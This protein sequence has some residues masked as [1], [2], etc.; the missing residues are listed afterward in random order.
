M[1]LDLLFYL[2][3]LA[4]ILVSRRWKTGE[5]S[6][7]FIFLGLPLFILVAMRGD[8]GTDTASYIEQFAI[9]L[10]GGELLYGSFEPG[11]EFLATVLLA[12]LNDAR[13]AVN[14]ISAV[15]VVLALAV[16]MRWGGDWRFCAA[17]V[18]PAF[19]FDFTMN[20]LR[21]GLAFPL[22]VYA[23]ILFEK[24][25]MVGFFIVLAI[26]SSIQITAMPLA[27]LLLIDKISILLKPK[28]VIVFMVS[29]IVLLYGAGDYLIERV[30]SKA[31]FYELLQKPDASSGTAPLFFSG[32]L[33]VFS[34][35]RRYRPDSRETVFYSLVFSG[36][37]FAAYQV[38]QVTYAGLR[39][40][41]LVLFAQ[42][43]FVQRNIFPMFKNRIINNL[44][45]F[46]L[47][48][49]FTFWKLRSFVVEDAG[50]PSPFLP[51]HFFWS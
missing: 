7:T 41:L 18:I 3:P 42:M 40:Q 30:L 9:R 10:Q 13:L 11:F 8:V 17:A 32:L 46:G 31:D 43:L 27:A 34:I 29:A 47:F 44:L 20:G 4:A 33:F 1:F 21:I 15:N 6:P 28:A 39:I 51:Y 48:A 49:M 45:V 19:I 38:S 26:A 37:Q 16:L 14:V 25:N 24:K 5:V 2:F 50:G 35:I 23:V 36:L 12:V 22:V